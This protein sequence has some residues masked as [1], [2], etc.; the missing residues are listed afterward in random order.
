MPERVLNRREGQE[1]VGH[2]N[3][4]PAAKTRRYKETTGKNE[5]LPYV[6][7]PHAESC[8][9]LGSRITWVNIT[10]DVHSIAG[11]RMGNLETSK[12]L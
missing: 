5:P 4:A 7:S 8:R 12:E 1:E 3:L 6:A 2:R 9:R 10:T 11:A